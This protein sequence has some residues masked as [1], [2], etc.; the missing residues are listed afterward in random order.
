MIHLTA[1]ALPWVCSLHSWHP[2]ETGSPD[3]PCVVLASQSQTPTQ[4][5]ALST[6]VVSAK[7]F[8]IHFKLSFT[9]RSVIKMAHWKKVSELIS[10]YW[11]REC[12]KERVYACRCPVTNAWH[13]SSGEAPGPQT[14]VWLSERDTGGVGTRGWQG[15]LGSPVGQGWVRGAGVALPACLLTDAGC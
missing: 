8:S 7:S 13:T 9:N 10:V 12:R 15:G 4:L 1:I 6:S 11:E 3:F 14:S 2:A 5:W